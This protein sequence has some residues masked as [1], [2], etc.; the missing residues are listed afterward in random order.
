MKKIALALL[1]ASSMTAA[2]RNPAN[3]ERLLLPF[4]GATNAAGGGYW[5]AQWWFRNDGDTNADVFPL[6][7]SCG[8]CPKPFEFAI[9]RAPT[10][11]ARSTPTYSPGDVKFGV[12][13]VPIGV[14][15]DSSP[16]GGLLY[17]ERGKAGQLS[18]SGFLARL[19]VTG[20]RPS[21][22]SA[23][24]PVPDTRF[25]AGTHSIF[26][27][28]IA[29]GSR[30]TL[31]IFALPESVDSPLVTVRVFAIANISEIAQNPETLLRT[32]AV[33]FVAADSE[34]FRVK[35]LSPCDD[36]PRVAYKPSVAERSLGELLGESQT[37]PIRI[38]IEPVSP[39]VKWWAIISATDSSDNV[40]LFEASDF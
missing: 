26:V 25:R 39:N 27:P 40:Q 16:P 18:I 15:F 12:P 2:E 1:L 4:T 7:V 38:E 3:Y 9:L 13:L 32:V 17:V 36:L 33:H 10:L 21:V 6:A 34:A 22:S 19:S 29:A 5:F 28:P 20:T 24:H 8:L 31:R 14:A 30:Y 23:L 37:K 35:C 11:P